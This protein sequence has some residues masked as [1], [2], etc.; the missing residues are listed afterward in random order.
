MNFTYKIGVD[1]VIPRNEADLIYYHLKSHPDTKRYV[2]QG[3]FGFAFVNFYKDTD[4]DREFS[5]RELDKILKAL[6]YPIHLIDKNLDQ[7]LKKSVVEKLT[8]W[9][10]S[11]NAEYLRLTE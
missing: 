11:I 5:F 8:K 10:H 7:E 3:E 4:I 1:V 6:E 9:C 2:Q